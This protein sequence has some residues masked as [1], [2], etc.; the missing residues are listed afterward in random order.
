VASQKPLSGSKR[1]STPARYHNPL[2]AHTV[3]SD[4]TCGR[5]DHHS[6]G[7]NPPL[8]LPFSHIIP[9]LVIMLISFAYLEG[10]ACC[11][12]FLASA[13]AS[14]AITAATVWATVY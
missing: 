12:A 3:R 9:P 4:Q 13:L 8:P 11:C 1:F 10:E 5:L 14:F 6:V 7:R 2:L